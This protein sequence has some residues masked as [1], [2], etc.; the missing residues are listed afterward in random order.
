MNLTY[1]GQAYTTSNKVAT[2]STK[3]ML[4]YRGQSYRPSRAVL[5]VEPKIISFALAEEANLIYR[6]V[7]YIHSETISL[8]HLIS[9]FS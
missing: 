3:I 4:T 6:G 7:P 9:I 2:V 5:N 8:Y 1:R